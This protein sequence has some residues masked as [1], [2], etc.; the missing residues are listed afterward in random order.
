MAVTWNKGSDLFYVTPEIT[1]GNQGEV[2]GRRILAQ[3]QEAIKWQRWQGCH[4][5]RTLGGLVYE[6]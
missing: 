5:G 2:T 6:H 1:L 3:Y 4:C